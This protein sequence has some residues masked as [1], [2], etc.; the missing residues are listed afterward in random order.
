MNAEHERLFSRAV[1]LDTPPSNM[2]VYL[3]AA[4]LYPEPAS[5]KTEEGQSPTVAVRRDD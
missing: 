2:T 5:K 3:Q 1:R 4:A